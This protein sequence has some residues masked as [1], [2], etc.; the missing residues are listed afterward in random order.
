MISII[1]TEYVLLYIFTFNKKIIF[2]AYWNNFYYRYTE[3]FV[4]GE[5]FQ[6]E[7]T[8]IW[9]CTIYMRRCLHLWL[10][11]QQRIGFST[12][13]QQC[14]CLGISLLYYNIRSRIWNDSV[15]KYATG[16]KTL[17]LVYNF[18]LTC[19]TFEKPSPG[20]T[21]STDYYS[22]ATTFSHAQLMFHG[23]QFIS[24]TKK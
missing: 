17:H 2:L 15:F 14:C 10:E 6:F 24:T 1:S 23:I 18:S 3:I 9:T 5:T 19:V 12:K 11:E 20:Q 13:P 4:P 8:L 21:K 7:V 22:T 16:L